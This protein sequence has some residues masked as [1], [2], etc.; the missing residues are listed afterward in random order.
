MR[1]IILQ[2][3]QSPGD[4]IMLTAAVRDLHLSNPRKFTTDVRT[5]CPELWQNNPYITS[6]NKGDDNVELVECRYPLIHESNQYPL[7]FI[8]AFTEFLNGVL[9]VRSRVQHFKGDIH[10]AKEELSAPSPIIEIVGQ[11]I[12]YWIVCAGGKTDFT[13]KWWSR[14]RYQKVV[15]HFRG[16]IQFVQ[17]GSDE[18]HHSPLSG[19]I[20]ICGKTSLRDLVRWTYHAQ[21]VLCGVSLPMHL[22]AAVKTRHDRPRNRACVVIAGGREPPHWE[23]YPAHQFLHTVGQLRC[24]ERGGCWRART[25]ALGDGHEHDSSGMLC[26]DPRGELP[27]C[28][29]MITPEQVIASI[30][31]YFTGGS[32]EYISTK[33]VSLG[34]NAEVAQDEG[35]VEVSAA[36]Q[37]AVARANEF[38]QAIPPYPGGYEGR[39]IVICGGGVCYFTNVWVCVNMLRRHGC[40]LPVQ[41]WHLGPHE[42]TEE[43]VELIRPLNVVCVDASQVRES[44]PVRRLGG[45]ELKPYA[46]LHS[47][48]RE[49]MLIDADNVPVRSPEYLFETPEYRKTGALFW[50]DYGRLGPERSIWRICGVEYRNEPEFESGQIVVDKECCWE[51]LSLSMHYNEYS[52]FFYQHIHGDKD[53][54]H[55]A[56]RRLGVPYAMPSEG[57]HNLANLVMCQHDFDGQRLFQHRNLDKWHLTKGNRRIRG[58]L[59]ENECRE[60]VLQLRKQWDGQVL[61]RERR[62]TEGSHSELVARLEDELTHQIYSYCRIGHDQRPMTFETDGRVGRG[63]AELE[64][65]WA[66]RKENAHTCLEISSRSQVTCRL[67][68]EKGGTWKGQ[69]IVNEGMLIELTPARESDE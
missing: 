36:E 44:H 63:A 58:F 31:G 12:P 53:T 29:E 56:F 16:L 30:E 4:I 2:N 66:L 42:M 40:Q 24:S 39:G 67:G 1:R 7:H 64:M 45:W 21:G 52:D 49:V 60:Y 65:F 20:D 68:R 32:L 57:I 33:T 43:M 27:R 37:E 55:M 47:P 15:N 11:D 50:P 61:G 17:I 9:Q 6:L 38:I 8:H 18:H 41:L 25:Q 19:V 48:F 13:V 10:L 28:M 23:H 35:E 51:A 62:G 46:I 34:E 3:N 59:Y 22:A 54:F 5:P 69:W 14:E 26:V